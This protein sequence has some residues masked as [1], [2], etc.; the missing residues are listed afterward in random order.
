MKK[1]LLYLYLEPFK[2]GNGGYTHALGMM[3]ALKKYYDIVF[4]SKFYNKNTPLPTDIKRFFIILSIQL[5]AFLYLK[6]V[7][8]CYVRSH[9]MGIFF[10][11]VA[12][13][14]RKKILLEVNGPI[15]DSF[16]HRKICALIK[17]AVKFS[18][19]LQLRIADT[20]TVVTPELKKFLIENYPVLGN[21]V[22]VIPNAAFK[23]SLHKKTLNIVNE[24]SSESDVV[25]IGSLTRWQGIETLLDAIQIKNVWPQNLYLDIYGIGPIL[26]VIL[27]A[28]EQNRL[29]RYK[30]FLDDEEKILVYAKAL[31][32]VIPKNNLLDRNSTGLSPIKL[33]ESLAHST[34]VIVTDLS[35]MSDIVREN[36]LGVVVPY[37][38]SVELAKAV[39]DLYKNKPLRDHL[40]ENAYSFILNGNTW[41]DR[42]SQVHDIIC[43]L[44]KSPIY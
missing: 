24:E 33:Y 26:P 17:Q 31:F 41:D 7:D 44:S 43:E 30:G 25:Y 18:F 42:A 22:H 3:D 14:C 40:S 12:F 19:Y 9:F 15:T 13:L 39:R 11:I 20:V 32:S 2:K 38:S 16:I 27:K 37:E 8:Y 29:I 36:N 10:C 4:F 6:R 21:R 34:P 5:R 23:S 35:Y 1:K 28:A